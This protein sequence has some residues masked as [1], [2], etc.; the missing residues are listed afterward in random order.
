[1]SAGPKKASPRSAL[2][3]AACLSAA[4]GLGLWL[5]FD[6][7]VQVQE[8]PA[9]PAITAAPSESAAEPERKTPWVARTPE[10]AE[11][12]PEPLPPLPPGTTTLD[13]LETLVTDVCACEDMKCVEEANLRHNRYFGQAERLRDKADLRPLTRRAAECV[14]EIRKDG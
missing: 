10:P 6:P 2:P 13:L 1:M 12:R 8:G 7:P 3:V 14:A 11:M 9:A 5:R 4:L